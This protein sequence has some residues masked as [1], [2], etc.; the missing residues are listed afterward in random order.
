MITL[1]RRINIFTFRC[2]PLADIRSDIFSDFAFE[3][4]LAFVEV[5][6]FSILLPANCFPIAQIKL[7]KECAVPAGI[8]VFCV[9][10]IRWKRVWRATLLAQCITPRGQYTAIWSAAKQ[11]ETKREVQLI[12]TESISLML[13]NT[14]LSCCRAVAPGSHFFLLGSMDTKFHGAEGINFNCCRLCYTFAGIV[15]LTF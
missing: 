4:F 3:L 9:I 2:S 6:R 11:Q 8:N 5:F 13:L 10:G 14:N 1:F 15:L 12:S 7:F